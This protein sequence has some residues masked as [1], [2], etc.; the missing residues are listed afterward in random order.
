MFTSKM[1]FLFSVRKKYVEKFYANKMHYPFFKAAFDAYDR[2]DPLDVFFDCINFSDKVEDLPV[3]LASFGVEIPDEQNE[4]DWRRRINNRKNYIMLLYSEQGEF[5]G[6]FG[7][8]SDFGCRD[9]VDLRRKYIR[10]NVVWMWLVDSRLKD[11]VEK[12]E[13]R[14][15]FLAK[16]KALGPYE[17][18]FYWLNIAG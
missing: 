2:N 13:D 15:K 6:D 5:I 16:G 1:H 14:E 7:R 12:N 17:M 11:K 9:V 10:K 8:S 3:K 4:D 18:W